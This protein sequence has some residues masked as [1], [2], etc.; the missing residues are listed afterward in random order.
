VTIILSKKACIFRLFYWT[1]VTKFAKVKE[2]LSDILLPE[3]I[4]HE[5][6]NYHEY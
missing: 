2:I 3:R 5:A 6:T 1:K 4:F